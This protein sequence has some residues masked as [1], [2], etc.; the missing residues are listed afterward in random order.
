[1]NKPDKRAVKVLRKA[2]AYLSVKS[3][4]D[5]DETDGKAKAVCVFG[6]LVKFS[7][8]ASLYVET[9]FLRSERET[10]MNWR[11]NP[12]TWGKAKMFLKRAIKRALKGVKP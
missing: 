1:M 8:K 10:C 3:H 2:L 12:L 4:F 6:A 11:D 7:G 9:Y 5:P